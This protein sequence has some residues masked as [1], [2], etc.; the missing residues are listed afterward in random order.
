MLAAEGQEEEPRMDEDREGQQTTHRRRCSWP[1]P[2][3][4]KQPPKQPSSATSASKKKRLQ[5][6]MQ[7]IRM[8]T[9]QHRPVVVRKK[10]KSRICATSAQSPSVTG[11]LGRATT[12]HAMSVRCA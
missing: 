9:V 11:C 1:I 7:Q 5:L 12:V 3:N 2:P 8:R 10:H 6:Q 4:C